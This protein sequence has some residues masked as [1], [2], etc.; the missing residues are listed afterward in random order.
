MEYQLNPTTPFSQNGSIVD[1]GDGTR[2]I[3][4]IINPQIVGDIYGFVAPGS[5]KNM[6]SVTFPSV[7]KDADQIDA[8]ILAAA[9]TFCTQQYPNTP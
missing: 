9:T 6:T 5:G 8:L 1:N 4:I 2:T 7:G 3:P